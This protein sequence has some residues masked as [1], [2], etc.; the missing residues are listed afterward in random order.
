MPDRNAEDASQPQ[1]GQPTPAPGRA[2]EPPESVGRRAR[3]R[4]LRIGAAATLIAVVVAV[5]A[6][7][8]GG[9]SANPAS[10]LG[11]AAAHRINALLAGIPENGNTLGSPDAPVTLEY[12]G[13][14][15]CSTARAFTLAAL[16]SIIEKWVRSGTLRIEYRSLRTV[17]A[18]NVFGVQQVAALA[19]GMQDKQWYYLE[20]FYQEQE[21]EHTHYVTEG[22]LHDLA[23]Q[24]PGLNLERWSHDRH[25]PE[26]ATQVARDE[27]IARTESLHSTPS[28]L[29]GRTGSATFHS[30]GGFSALD[31]TPVNEAVRQ[32][33]HNL[34]GRGRPA[35][36][37]VASIGSTRLSPANTARHD[38][39]STSVEIPNCPIS[40]SPKPPV[41]RRRSKCVHACQDI[42]DV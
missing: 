19:A 10:G 23:R 24:I 7:G 35:L 20:Y 1:D 4:A 18:P 25:N 11:T 17:S 15:E 12:Y 40:C 42:E 29:I 34:S 33:L 9:S 36:S 8:G 28:L 38:G 22:Y 3:T 26:L 31:P 5:I 2:E 32:I 13:D 30:L 21:Q 37:T 6:T 41:T 39:L 14:L 27:Q 16:P